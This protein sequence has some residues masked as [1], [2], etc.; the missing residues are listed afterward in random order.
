MLDILGVP[1]GAYTLVV[2]NATSDGSRDIV[3]TGYVYIFGNDPLPPE[4]IDDP[5]LQYSDGPAMDC[6]VVTYWGKDL[7]A[8]STG[9]SFSDKRQSR[10]RLTAESGPATNT[11]LIIQADYNRERVGRLTRGCTVA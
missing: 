10:C 5:C 3:G 2:R 11:L 4:P 6:G 7:S 9:F 8:L 1:S